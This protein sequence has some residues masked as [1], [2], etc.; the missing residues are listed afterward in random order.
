MNIKKRFKLKA[1]GWDEQRKNYALFKM[2]VSHEFMLA[3]KSA[4]KAVID[5]IAMIYEEESAK[6]RDAGKV[7]IGI[8]ID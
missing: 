2:A 7:G 5:E 1:D 6:F 3:F 4:Q 8:I